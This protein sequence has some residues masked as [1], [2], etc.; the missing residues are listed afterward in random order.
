MK[1]AVV[2]LY[3]SFPP[4]CGAASVTYNLAKHIPWEKYLIQ[5][6]GKKD[7]ILKESST[8]L[9]NLRILSDKTPFKGIYIFSQIRKIIRKIKHIKPDLVILEGAS[10]TVYVLMLYCMIRLNRIDAKIIY[11]AHNVEFLLRKQKNNIFIALIT[12]WAEGQLIS[13]ANLCTAVSKEDADHFERLYGEKL[14]ILP[15]GVDVSFFDSTTDLQIEKIKSKYNLS[16]NIVLFMGLTSFKPNKEAIDFLVHDVFPTVVKRCPEAKLAIIGGEI[17]Y[18]REWLLNPGI[19]PFEEV[20]AFVKACDVC[21][22]PVFSGSGTRVKI[23]EYMAAKK[24]VLSTTKGA[25]GISYQAGETLVVADTA[26]K[27]V[28]EILC[29]L[30]ET[31]YAEKLGQKGSELVRAHYAWP[32]IMEDF[33]RHMEYLFSEEKQ[34]Q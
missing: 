19:I 18:K 33:S 15:N 26:N 3:E 23:L 9:I 29:L 2:S 4:V 11:H 5:I 25:E 14:L 31:D 1:V 32:K 34:P 24:P 30:R 16:K 13:K 8:N 28:E 27:F 6:S 21:V 17:K 22:A 20:P 10:W 7:F 12:K